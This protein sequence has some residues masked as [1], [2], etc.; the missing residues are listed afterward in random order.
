MLTHTNT[1]NNG[2]LLLTVR[3]LE[4]IEFLVK[5]NEVLSGQAGRSFVIA[6]ADRLSYRVHWHP[7][8]MKV[9]RLDDA[10]RVMHIQ[11]LPSHEFIG[12]SLVAALAAGQLFT[13]PVCRLG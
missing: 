12:H 4:D 1:G 5:E 11:H 13:P 8:G 2:P 7:L 10:G 6:G 3:A 9:E